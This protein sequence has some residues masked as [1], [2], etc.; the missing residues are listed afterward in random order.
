M[1]ADRTT[2]SGKHDNER[3]APSSRGLIPHH[4]VSWNGV[5]QS[6]RS[7]CTPNLYNIVLTDIEKSA[8]R[9][10]NGHRHMRD[11]LYNIV[12]GVTAA[13]GGLDLEREVPYDDRGDGLR[14]ILP[15]DQLPP[16][17]V[18]DIFVLGL[19]AALR[20][21]R[22]YV[23]AAARIRM[24]VCFDIGLLEHHRRSWTGDP[25]VRAAR[26]VDA[27][28]VRQL[29]IDDPD[30]DLSVIVSDLMYEQIIRP[31]YGY[32]GPSCFRKVRVSIKEFD[33]CAWLLVPGSLVPPDFPRVDG[34]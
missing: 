32:I 18:L 25:L 31:G 34:P 13:Y 3:P 27:Q 19:Y 2:A 21:H 29:L 23:S 14:L 22:Q 16:T 6:R 5:N 8:S 28:P 1:S 24:R 9:S 11:D 4:G 26:L 33:G 17:R 12:A 10:G 15:I 7:A 30:T 20:E